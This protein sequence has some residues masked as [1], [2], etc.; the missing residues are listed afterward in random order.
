MQK[1]AVM[2]YEA[3][4]FPIFQQFKA[5]IFRI[6]TVFLHVAVFRFHFCLTVAAVIGKVTDSGRSCFLYYTA[7]PVIGK[8]FFCIFCRFAQQLIL[9]IIKIPDFSPCVGFTNPV[10]RFIVCVPYRRTIA[11]FFQKL[12][13]D[14]I[15]I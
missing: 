3:G 13:A 4:T 15:T 6:I 14:I 2:V 8:L 5:Q 9:C 11:P 7:L 12:S 10:A 1:L